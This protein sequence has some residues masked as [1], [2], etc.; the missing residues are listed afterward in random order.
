MTG[1][2]NQRVVI[3]RSMRYRSRVNVVVIKAFAGV[4]NAFRGKQHFGRPRNILMAK[5]GF[6]METVFTN[7][8]VAID[9]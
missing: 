7:K 9:V 2:A 3:I 6:K 1:G 5:A 4:L 8:V